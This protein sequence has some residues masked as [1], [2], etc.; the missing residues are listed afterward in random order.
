MQRESSDSTILV[1][2]TICPNWNVLH[3]ETRAEEKARKDKE[4][5]AKSSYSSSIL[6]LLRTHQR[7]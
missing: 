4:E 7:K 3:H 1:V 2:L 6:L 5:A